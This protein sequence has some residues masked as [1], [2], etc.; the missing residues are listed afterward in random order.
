MWLSNSKIESLIKIAGSTLLAG[1][2]F[3]PFW[4]PAVG[5]TQYSH[6]FA[7]VKFET[8]NNSISPN[9]EIDVT[10][11]LD[12]LVTP[13]F[14]RSYDGCVVRPYT[15][16]DFIWNGIRED[17]GET[18]NLRFAYS[19]VF[20][21]IQNNE[22]ISGPF[23]TSV[24]ML[25]NGDIVEGE[26]DGSDMMSAVQEIDSSTDDQADYAGHLERLGTQ[27]VQIT[28]RSARS[29][30]IK[31]KVPG[32]GDVLVQYY[33]SVEQYQ[34]GDNET[35]ESKNQN[36]SDFCGG[37]TAFQELYSTGK[38]VFVLGNSVKLTQSIEKFFIPKT[39]SISL[40]AL[41]LKANSSA[42]GP[43][44]FTTRTPSICLVNNNLLIMR[45]TGKCKVEAVA[46]E[47]QKFSKSPSVVKVV[48]IVPKGS[49]YEILCLKAL[50]MKSIVGKSPKC[51]PGYKEL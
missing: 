21:F 35:E 45:K 38:Q 11:S 17:N 48:A 10:F 32:A 3:S 47:T 36:N 4:M 7:T 6:K 14:A 19:A 30:P 5:A 44:R 51:P 31:F 39:S 26:Q 40:Q 49:K 16:S 42:G 22:I 29:Y 25:H 24:A 12:S 20:Q 33:F 28:G 34:T 18:A 15:E 23:F 50:S 8:D 46:I 9:E 41:Q 43:V 27:P 13:S 2:M 1:L 37:V